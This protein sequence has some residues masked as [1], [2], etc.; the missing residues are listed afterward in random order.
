MARERGKVKWFD[1]E[2]GHGFIE[3]PDGEDLFVE[4]ADINMDF[5]SLDNGDTVEFDAVEYD[6]GY[7]AVNV[8]KVG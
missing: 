5:K 2:R 1:N 3:R 8:V 6:R 7:K 4:Y